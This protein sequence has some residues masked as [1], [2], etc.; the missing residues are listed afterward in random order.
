[1]IQQSAVRGSRAQIDMDAYNAFA[2][3][4]CLNTE[5]LDVKQDLVVDLIGG[6]VDKGC[7]QWNLETDR[8]KSGNTYHGDVSKRSYPYRR[9]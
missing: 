5:N 6:G 9:V 4:V 1:M 7:C 3:N 8:C 2:K